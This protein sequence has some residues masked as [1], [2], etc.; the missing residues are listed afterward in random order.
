VVINAKISSSNVVD[1]ISVEGI[2]VISRSSDISDDGERDILSENG[3]NCVK[4]DSVDNVVLVGSKI[5]SVVIISLNIVKEVSKGKTVKL[6]V[7]SIE[8]INV[9]SETGDVL[10]SGIDKVDNV[11]VLIGSKISSVNVVISIDTVKGNGVVVSNIS[12]IVLSI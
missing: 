2:I 7:V 12:G 1:V 11:V 10:S 3:L 4:V 9:V 8:E 5:S 6:Y